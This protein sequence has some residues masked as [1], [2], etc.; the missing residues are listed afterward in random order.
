MVR[1]D[2]YLSGSESYHHGFQNG[3]SGA[4]DMWHDLAP[5]TN[6]IDEIYYSAN[7]YT[8][9]ARHSQIFNQNGATSGFEMRFCCLLSESRYLWCRG[10]QSKHVLN[11]AY[12]SLNHILFMITIFQA[13][14]LISNHSTDTP[15]FMYLPYQNVRDSTSTPPTLSSL[16]LFLSLS[17]SLSLSR[18]LP[19]MS[20]HRVSSCLLDCL[21]IC[22]RLLC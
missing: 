6:V 4:H 17:L 5:G 3:D 9:T 16:S 19:S 2:R 1:T 18:P 22:A 21:C 13:I 20:C 14:S 12:R 8:D 7:F 10:S 15:F 11:P